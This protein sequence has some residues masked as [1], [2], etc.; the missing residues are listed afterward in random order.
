[1]VIIIISHN[2]SEYC[3]IEL[4]H[5]LQRLVNRFGK[6]AHGMLVV[7]DNYDY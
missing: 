1:M 2:L 5:Y 7:L 4:E 3:D 6:F